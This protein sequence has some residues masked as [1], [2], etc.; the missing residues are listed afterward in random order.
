MVYR[1]HGQNLFADPTRA[2]KPRYELRVRTRRV[3]VDG[4]KAWLDERGYNLHQPDLHAFFKQWELVQQKDE[5][6]AA[7]P[8]RVQISRHL[9][10]YAHFYAPQ[11]TWRHRAVTYANA[12]GSLVVGYKNV[13]LLDERRVAVKRALRGAAG[14]VVAGEN[15]RISGEERQTPR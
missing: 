9:M 6:V 15:T 4:M 11:L 7:P 12:A 13:H 5:F 14:P 8:G 2:N 10:Q 3:L 1:V